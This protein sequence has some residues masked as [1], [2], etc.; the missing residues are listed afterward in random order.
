MAAN[1]PRMNLDEYNWNTFY[2]E[3]QQESPRAAV[4]IS[5]A[6]LDS[7]LGDLLASFM[8]DNKIVVNELLGTENN[9]DKPLG[10]FGPRIKTAYC[11]GLISEIE[12]ED[13]K[14]I[15]K[16]RNKFAH[17]MHGFSFEQKEIVDLCNKLKY[18]KHF[19][20]VLIY[21]DFSSPESKYEFTVSMLLN[22]LGV[23][24]LSVQR[25]RRITPGDVQLNQAVIVN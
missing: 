15:N 2:E 5:G 21:Q 25:E 24:I 4:I 23:Q 11:L 7:L 6:F 8:V 22:Q 16:I 3:F 13:L 19:E 20:K 10:F 9:P 1:P 18:P 14:L 12:F 17:K